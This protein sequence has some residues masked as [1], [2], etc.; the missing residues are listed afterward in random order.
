MVWEEDINLNFCQK[1]SSDNVGNCSHKT[2][3]DT[4]K[5]RLHIN[6]MA[7]MKN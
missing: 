4:G 1:N 2:L 5:N 7:S 3:P 6:L